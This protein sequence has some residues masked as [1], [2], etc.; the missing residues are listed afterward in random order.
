M[1]TKYQNPHFVSLAE[2]EARLAIQSRFNNID[3]VARTLLEKLG[4]ETLI[5]TL[6]KRGSISVDKKGDTQLTPVFSTKVIDTVGAGDA[7]FSY[8]ALCFAKH[9]PLDLI[10]FIG[11][12]VGAIAVQ[13]VCN[14]KSVERHEL[15]ELSYALLKEN[16]KVL[17]SKGRTE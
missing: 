9:L 12:A 13:I 4:A 7:V 15:L 14:K 16:S 11:N 1:I 6:G 5:V 2:T 3:A 17:P 10:S 8:T